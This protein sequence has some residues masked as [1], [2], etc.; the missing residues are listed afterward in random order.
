MGACDGALEGEVDGSFVS[1]G[2]CW[3][4]SIGSEADALLDGDLLGF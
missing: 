4:E 3:L 1:S 2:T